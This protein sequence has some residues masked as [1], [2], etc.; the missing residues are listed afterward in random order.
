ME[1]LVSRLPVPSFLW[2][3]LVALVQSPSPKLLLSSLH[4]CLLP[5][6]AEN[7]SDI[8]LHLPAPAWK[9]DSITPPGPEPISRAG[10]AGGWMLKPLCLLPLLSPLALGGEKGRQGGNLI[11]ESPAQEGPQ[12]GQHLRG[13]QMEAGPPSSLYSCP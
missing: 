5:N 2:A 6:E 9:D 11:P 7:E 10:K 13:D 12:G 4:L 1:A 8:V 3:L